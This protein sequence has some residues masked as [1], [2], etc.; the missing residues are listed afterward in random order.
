[1]EIARTEHKF[2][3][4]L[5]MAVAVAFVEVGGKLAGILRRIFVKGVEC[6]EV[7]QI[8]HIVVLGMLNNGVA[9]PVH[10]VEGA[11]RLSEFVRQLGEEGNKGR[12]DVEIQIQRGKPR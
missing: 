8:E 7:V 4:A 3:L 6:D 11:L 9:V 1:M 5:V 12:K 2:Y 10:Q